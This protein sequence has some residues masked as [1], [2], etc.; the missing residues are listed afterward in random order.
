MD[1]Q[2]GTTQEE[3][4]ERMRVLVKEMDELAKDAEEFLNMLTLED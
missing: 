3:V 2:V 1:N 4:M